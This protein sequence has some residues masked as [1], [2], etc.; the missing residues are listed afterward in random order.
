MASTICFEVANY[1]E[2]KWT[3]LEKWA[4]ATSTQYSLNDIASVHTNH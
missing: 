2:V 4:T 3:N 1:V